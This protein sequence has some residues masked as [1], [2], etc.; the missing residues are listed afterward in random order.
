[1]SHPELGRSLCSILAAAPA[2]SFLIYLQVLRLEQMAIAA[3]IVYVHGLA[4]AYHVKAHRL[5][6]SCFKAAH[7]Q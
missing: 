5:G 6:F 4:D 1:M 2:A 3:N 7:H